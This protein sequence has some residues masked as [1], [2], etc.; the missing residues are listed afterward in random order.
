MQV[1]MQMRHPC[2]KLLWIDLSGSR[3]E[4]GVLHGAD[5][6]TL[7]MMMNITELQ[8]HHLLSEH[9]ARHDVLTG[10][11]NRRRRGSDMVAR[12]GDDE[13]IVL[14]GG[15]DDAQEHHNI[16]TRMGCHIAEPVALS[17]EQ[18]VCVSASMALLL[19]V[20]GRP[21]AVLARRFSCGASFW[22]HL[23]PCVSRHQNK[24]PPAGG[25]LFST[26]SGAK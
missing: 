10:L 7:R 25:F 24:K 4:A 11:P 18:L 17:G 20:R 14:L 12:S 3:L 5:G 6:Q 8:E 21:D 19:G 22:V 1:Q 23:A 26:I 2:G 15:Q 16:L 9:L 13:F